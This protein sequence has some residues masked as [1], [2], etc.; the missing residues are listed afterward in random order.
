MICDWGY[1]RRNRDVP[2]MKNTGKEMYRIDTIPHTYT[3]L[4]RCNHSLLR[5]MAALAYA[6]S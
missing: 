1:S 4:G 3:A 6:S 2:G 5:S